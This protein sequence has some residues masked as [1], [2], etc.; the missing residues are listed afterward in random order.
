M[1]SIELTGIDWLGHGWLLLLA[2]T[3][4][5]LVVAVLRQPC[6]HLFGT[7]RAF[8]LWL[9]P[10]LAMLASQLPH[11]ATASTATLPSL[12]Y[13][14]TSVA[15]VLPVHD[16]TA[17][18]LDW[19]GGIVLLWLTGVVLSLL[20]ACIAQLRYRRRLR[21]ATPVRGLRIR[22]PVLR[23]SSTNIGPALVGAWRNRI[24]LPA[25]FERRYDAAEQALILVHEATHAHRRDGCWCLFAQVTAAIFWFHPL[26]GGHWRR[27]ATTRS[28]LATRP[29]C[30]STGRSDA[31]MRMP[32]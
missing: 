20:R 7:E 11:V 21:D 30:A 16:A 31:V 9:L 13:M 3:A 26:A 27:C 1:S 10:P 4:S 14:V 29:C 15:G 18:R 6:R 25:D 12:V 8:Q 32:C 5:V 23:A 22:W 17:D 24:V 2:F 19:R 28:W